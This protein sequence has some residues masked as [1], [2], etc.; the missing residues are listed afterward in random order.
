MIDTMVDG[1]KVILVLEY[2]PG[3][4]ME[5]YIENKPDGRLTE[6]KSRALFRQIVSG[7]DY[8]HKNSI[9]HRYVDVFSSSF[10]YNIN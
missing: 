7:V 2:V 8:L 10:K 4:D 6:T 1:S 5:G 9:I 3:G